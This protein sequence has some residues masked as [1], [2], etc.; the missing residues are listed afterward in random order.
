MKTLS[1]LSCIIVC[2]LMLVQPGEAS[3]VPDDVWTGAERR[4]AGGLPDGSYALYRAGTKDAVAAWYG[5]PTRRYR[6]AI[7]G[8]DIEAGSLHVATRD[9][10]LFE[11]AA[12]ASDG[13]HPGPLAYAAWSEMAETALAPGL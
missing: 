1:Q 13:F 3:D 8:D 2:L 6:H 7:L 4:P 5:T 10:R 11:P 12:M 9:G